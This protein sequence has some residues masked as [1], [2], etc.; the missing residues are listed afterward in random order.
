LPITQNGSG[1]LITP[2][3]SAT[4]SISILRSQIEN[5]NGGGIHTDSSNGAINVDIADS[6]IS[7]NASN[8]FNVASGAGGHNNMVSIARTTIANNGLVGIQSGGST[9]AVLLDTT[10]LDSNTSGA[11]DVLTGARILSYGNNRIVGAP[12]SGFTGPASLQ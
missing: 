3:G 1:I 5:N 9:S 8:G 2:T 4:A 11:T 10:L 6:A 12:G 7:N